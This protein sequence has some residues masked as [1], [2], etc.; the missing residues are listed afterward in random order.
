MVGEEL[1]DVERFQQTLE[2]KD[3]SKCGALAPAGGLYFM[4]VTY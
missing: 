1:W 2:T 3:R 4:E